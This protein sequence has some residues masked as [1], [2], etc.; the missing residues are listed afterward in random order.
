MT[1]ARRRKPRLRSRRRFT[2]DDHDATP[3]RRSWSQQASVQ[4]GSTQ[5]ARI[6]EALRDAL[7]CERA[8][9]R[10]AFRSYSRALRSCEHPSVELVLA[11]VVVCAATATVAFFVVPRPSELATPITFVLLLGA[12]IPLLAIGVRRMARH[13]GVDMKGNW[14]AWFVLIGTVGTLF[15]DIAHVIAAG[16]GAVVVL[17]PVA[18]V[19][20]I[21]DAAV[22]TKSLQVSSDNPVWTGISIGVFAYVL[23]AAVADV[24]S[25]R[26]LF[27][28]WHAIREA[29]VGLRERRDHVLQFMLF[30]ALTFL[31][32]GEGALGIVYDQY[33]QALAV[34][35]VTG[36]F[37]GLSLTTEEDDRLAVLARLGQ[38][39]C[40]LTAGQIDAA[41]WRVNALGQRAVG[42]WVW[43][44][45]YT[46]SGGPHASVPWLEETMY[47]PGRILYEQ[48]LRRSPLGLHAMDADDWHNRHDDQDRG[49]PESYLESDQWASGVAD[50]YGPYRE[51]WLASVANT[52]EVVASGLR[53]HTSGT[54]TWDAG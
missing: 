38:I 29:L 2:T 40:N 43:A 35:A 5:E 16:V 27:I 45:H 19:L 3:L 54:S 23:V 7:A 6:R 22:G 15:G 26:V 24:S 20:G 33:W 47:V 18:L 46:K 31:I 34:A 1:M 39:R 28:P 44:R 36:A 8:A 32:V 42:P 21:V 4:L 13:R 30:L 14:A 10:R 48:V 37:V 11:A 53:V 52:R 51:E 50:H 12:V 41:R 49:R 9:P 17:L 25:V